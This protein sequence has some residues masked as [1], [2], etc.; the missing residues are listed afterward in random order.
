L[1]LQQFSQP[2]LLPLASNIPL[3]PSQ[4]VLPVQHNPGFVYSTSVPLLP[5]LST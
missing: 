3:Q 2:L 1:N 4:F 5:T